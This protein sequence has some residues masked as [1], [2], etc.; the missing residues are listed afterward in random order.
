MATLKLKRYIYSYLFLK[1]FV[2]LVFSY[3]WW[4]STIKTFCFWH[5]THFM[6]N[7]ETIYVS[8]K[9]RSLLKCSVAGLL[10]RSQCVSERS[11]NRPSTPRLSWFCPE[12]PTNT[13]LVPKL[14]VAIPYVTSKPYKINA[15]KLSA[16]AVQ[17]TKLSCQLTQYKISRKI[18]SN[19]CLFELFSFVQT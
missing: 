10:V 3:N 5:V 4:S 8:E 18:V 7:N 11:H 16:T 2:K 1:P 12:L 17:G 13:Q 15:W 19:H 14:P 9:L 6:I